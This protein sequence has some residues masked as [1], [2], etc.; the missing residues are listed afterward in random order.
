[1]PVLTPS[2]P[3]EPIRDDDG[4]RML[5]DLASRGLL[6]DTYRSAP[7]PVRAALY[8]AAYR[9]V[10]PIVFRR[11]TRAIEI[12]RGHMACATSVTRLAGE[13]LDHFHNDVESVVDDLFARASQRVRSLEAFITSH[14]T[15]ATIDGYRRRRGERGALQ[16]PRVPGWLAAALADDP[17]LVD[18]AKQILTWAGVEMTA[19]LE[20]WPLHAWAVRRS[21]VC[22][23]DGVSELTEVR[24]DIKTVIDAMRTREQ[25]YLSYVERPLSRKQTSVLGSPA[26]S[27]G[28]AEDLRPFLFVTRDEVADGH[29]SDLAHAAIEAI[30]TGLRQEQEPVALIVQVVRATFAGDVGADDID[31]PPHGMPEDHR[32]I[33][34]LMADD[35]QVRR[36]VAAI[37]QHRRRGRGRRPR[38]IR[39]TA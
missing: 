26:S 4:D 11:L 20:V 14:I 10:W 5:R 17:W 24:A 23:L 39:V 21:D 6:S 30:R 15:V 37:L 32:H 12:R 28:R 38:P 35:S 34:E 18:L 33:Q 16:R 1:M 9:V 25:W 13:C 29:L 27:T 2:H 36:V 8:Q 22:G 7:E 19:G 31:R 3:E